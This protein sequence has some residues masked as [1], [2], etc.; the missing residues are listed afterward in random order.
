MIVPYHIYKKVVGTQPISP[1]HSLF[2]LGGLNEQ[3]AL[4][5]LI[6]RSESSRRF[7]AAIS[8]AS[9]REGLSQKFDSETWCMLRPP[10]FEMGRYADV[11]H[12]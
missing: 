1:N 12:P 3:C 4:S 9:K 10:L 8:F 5:T 2:S 11:D 7:L 6:I